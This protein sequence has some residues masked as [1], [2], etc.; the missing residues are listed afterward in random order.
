MSKD[1]VKNFYLFS[2][3]NMIDFCFL[4]PK[5]GNILILYFEKKNYPPMD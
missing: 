1:N 5:I 4:F 3:Q 2:I